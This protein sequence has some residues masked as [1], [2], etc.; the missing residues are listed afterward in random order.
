MALSLHGLRPKIAAA[1]VVKGAAWRAG[2]LPGGRRAVAGLAGRIDPGGEATDSY[3]GMLA[4][5]LYDTTEDTTGSDPVYDPVAGLI[6]GT[7]SRLP[8]AEALAEAAWAQPSAGRHIAAAAAY[9]KP[10]RADFES[11]ALHYEHAYRLNPEDLRAVEGI[12]STGVRTHFDFTRIWRY[13]A[14]LRPRTGTLASPALWE[15]I[16][17]LFLRRPSRETLQRAVHALE[18][19]GDDLAGLHQLLLEVLSVRLQFLGQFRCAFWLRELM[20]RNRVAELRGIPLESALWFKHLL[21]AYAYLKDTEQL[22]RAAAKPRLDIISPRVQL[23]VEKLQADVAL[24]TGDIQ[25][26]LAHAAARREQLPLPQDEIMAELVTGRRIAVVGPAATEDELGRVIDSYDVVVRTRRL[27]APTRAQ[28]ARIGTRTDI[29][30]YSGRDLLKDY[31]DAAAAAASG[32]LKLAVTR[33]FYYEAL[34]TV[35]DWLRCA[36]FEFGLYFRGAPMGI[37]RIV[38]DLLQFDPAEIGIFHADFYAGAHAAAEGYR[39]GYG[40]FGPHRETN[41]VVM[42]HDLGYEF[43]C[44]QRLVA[45]GP[46]IAHGTADQVL[47]LYPEQY[48]TRL[49]TDSVLARPADWLEEPPRQ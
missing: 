17:A 16:G 21:G 30:Y 35:P 37:Q 5:L 44:M 10:Y 40:V 4:Q 2:R 28:A 29:A 6:P 22:N 14:A 31:D 47:S 8:E 7:A 41:D 3:R 13:A 45:A 19:R 23:Q 38:Y 9:R 18:A 43:R 27:A 1:A 36:R 24:F 46:V 25:P 32:H 33:P 15:P 39:S 11:A 42:M 20:A 26:L 49:E 34:E 48:I 12:I